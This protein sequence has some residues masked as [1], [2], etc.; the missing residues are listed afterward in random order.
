MEHEVNTEEL[1]A[2]EA[3]IEAAS[4]GMSRRKFVGTALGA[5]A[6]G[7]ILAACSSDDDG[8]ESG[9]G[10]SDGGSGSSTG[11]DDLDE[12]LQAS[13]LPEIS[14]DMATS[15]PLVLD[16]I[17]GGAEFL[18]A[19]VSAM[20][21]GR[22]QITSAPGGDLVP[23][24]EILQNVQT[25]AVPAG[26]TA[27]YYYVGVDPITQLSTAVPFGM[28]ARQHQS[29]MYEGGGLELI[30]GIYRERFGVI[31]FPAGNTGCQMGGWFNKEINSVADLGGLRMRIPGLGGAALAELGV[32]VQV[33]PGGEIYQSL[34]TGAIDAAEW[35]GPYDDLNQ[36]FNKVTQFYYYPGWWEP[37]PSLDFMVP[38]AEFDAL[39]EEY[40]AVLEA[41]CAYAYNNM[42]ARYDALNPPALAEIKQGDITIL[43]FPDDVLEAASGEVDKLLDANAAADSDYATVLDSYNTFRDGIGPWHGLAEKAMLDFLA[44]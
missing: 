43:P 25:G 10:G 3:V 34:E 22:F 12:A 21:G 8:G 15:W 20:T 32:S 36:E 7:G 40:Q 35:V 1:E 42:L 14:W 39:P 27:S 16:T 5:V 19:Q 23:P 6:A 26:H 38:A 28:T 9:D 33:I 11:D 17:Y 13:D 41:A 29:W 30:Q 18:A 37:G 2:A 24:L 31:N 4:G 44:T